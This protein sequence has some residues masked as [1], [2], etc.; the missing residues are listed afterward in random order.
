MR[1]MIAILLCLCLLLCGCGSNEAVSESV[2]AASEQA[3]AAEIAQAS[4]VEEA[5][6]FSVQEEP[7]EEETIPEDPAEL[8]KWVFRLMED[9]NDIITAYDVDVTDNT[10]ITQLGETTTSKSS[11]RVRELLAEDGSVTYHRSEQSS[12]YTTD[13][14]FLDGMIYKSDYSGY[15]KA[16]MDQ[17]AFMDEYGVFTEIE[18]IDENSYTT[19][20]AEATDAGYTLTY[21]DMTADAAMLFMNFYSER[22]NE[23]MS[24]LGMAVEI[25]AFAQSGVTELDKE[26]YPIRDDAAITMAYTLAGIECELHVEQTI[27]YNQVNTELQINVP[28]D[29]EDYMEMSDITIPEM[30][31]NGYSLTM[32]N[33]ALDYQNAMALTVSDDETEDVYLSTDMITYTSNESGLTAYWETAYL[34]NDEV[35]DYSTDE[36]SA[37]EGTYT[38]PAGAEIYSYDDYSYL[39]DISGFITY[40]ADSFDYGSNFVLTPDGETSLLTYDLNAEYVEM[41]IENYLSIYT[42]DLTI[43][44][45]SSCI[46][47]GTMSIVFDA[48]GM[49]IGQ[50][51]ECTCEA[52]YGD[53]ILTFTLTDAGFVNAIGS[54][55][56]I[57]G[58]S[59]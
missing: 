15:F 19:L 41:A 5:P 13:I 26:G 23:E 16:P 31:I 30:F 22:L 38:T 36:Y 43:S 33:F 18:G 42:S 3:S 34:L 14:W 46:S 47:S 2:S 53:T 40:S 54:N 1:K 25:T 21:G 28:I 49:I 48:S 8:G 51:L 24:D 59:N 20:T 10:T 52:T 9:T 29:D 7:V 58:T 55:V 39:T 35:L 57:G 50:S 17:D 32:S 11:Y 27:I 56:V 4:A 44:D 45:A 12:G 37:G 6:E